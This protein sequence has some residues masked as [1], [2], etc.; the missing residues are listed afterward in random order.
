MNR[1]QAL[2]AS[3]GLV[4]VAVVR[5]VRAGAVRILV[6]RSRVGRIRRALVS[7]THSFRAGLF[8]IYL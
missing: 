2:L 1:I 4:V 7:G 8:V 5:A 6:L 3:C